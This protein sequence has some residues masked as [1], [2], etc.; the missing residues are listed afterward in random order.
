MCLIVSM[1]TDSFSLDI[2]SDSAPVFEVMSR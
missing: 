2:V 1:V